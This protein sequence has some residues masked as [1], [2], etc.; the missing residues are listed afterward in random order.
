MQSNS[1]KLR[2][3][4]LRLHN[5]FSA[6]M[7]VASSGHS[8]RRRRLAGI[9]DDSGKRDLRRAETGKV[10]RFQGA[11]RTPER[12]TPSRSAATTAVQSKRITFAVSLTDGIR[13]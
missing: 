10:Q 3:I 1:L 6:K 5:I 2:L 12:S 13:P 8:A 11:S 4:P 7:G 9:T